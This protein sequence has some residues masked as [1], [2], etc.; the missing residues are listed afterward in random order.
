M[1][2]LL[3]QASAPGSVPSSKWIVEHH[4]EESRLLFAKA[5][6]PRIRDET[7]IIPL[8]SHVALVVEKIQVWRTLEPP[9]LLMAMERCILTVEPCGSFE[10]SYDIE[11]E[12]EDSPL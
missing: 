3:R 4:T 5:I 12:P 1:E 7:V 2:D 8:V 6:G 10:G 11:G 9:D